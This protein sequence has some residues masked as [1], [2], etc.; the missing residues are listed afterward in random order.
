MIINR[1]LLPVKTD[2]GVVESQADLFLS[3]AYAR[4]QSASYLEYSATIDVGNL[5]EGPG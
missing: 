4:A 2:D 3:E 1:L 5:V